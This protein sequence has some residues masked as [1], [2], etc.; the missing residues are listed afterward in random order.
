MTLDILVQQLKELDFETLDLNKLYE[1]VLDVDLKK[2]KAEEHFP[3]V[4]DPENY[5]RNI[6]MMH[7]IEAV[8]LAW[9]PGVAS[10]I[11]H[12]KGF[13]GVVGVLE[14][15]LE[16]KTFTLKDDQL[17]ESTIETGMPG[18]WIREEDGVIHLLQNTS[19][20]ETAIT[21][22]IYYP[23]LESFD[24]MEIFDVEQ[25][26]RGVL[27]NVAKTASWMEPASSFHE[28][29]DS[30][31][32]YVPFYKRVDAPSHVVSPVIP[33]PPKD[34]IQR[35]IGE[36]YAEQ[37]HVYDH[38][39][40]SHDSRSRYIERVNE[41]IAKDLREMTQVDSFLG[42]ACG[43]GRRLVHIRELSSRDFALS[44]VDLSEEMC[45]V[46]EERGIHMHNA[47]WLK[48]TL[49]EAPYDAITFLYA[50][51][52]I[53]SAE[54][55]RASLQKMADQLRVGGRL[56][57]DVFNVDDHSEWGPSAVRVYDALQLDHL[58]YERGDVFYRKSG[59]KATAYLHY[60]SETEIIELVT[61]VG[62][63]VVRT[64]H[65]GYTKRPGEIL[66]NSRDGVL[67]VIAEKS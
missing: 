23:P 12:H 13:W 53:A 51:G 4:S 39:D 66:E 44:G 42:I 48:A 2:L 3:K 28:I 67:F 26:R 33:K 17:L 59:G 37:A 49:E 20:T 63:K 41:I 30:A 19:D 14:G 7:P 29:K 5:A 54:D 46:A 27:N 45:K 64:H 9:P 38:F 11:H 58:G 10:A 21:L 61:S 50:F 32:T 24:G 36:Y 43:T 6:L 22:H 62:L 60:F 47:P 31:F 18:G 55:R 35:L 16:N 52:H 57:I 1:F 8:L 15:C 65:I 25:E 56:Y 40:S 34:T